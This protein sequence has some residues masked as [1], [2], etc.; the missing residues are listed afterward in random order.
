MR[1]LALLAPALAALALSGCA[2]SGEPDIATLASSSDDIIWEAAQKAASKKQWE[3]ARQHYKRIVDAF[4][5]SEHGADARLGLADSYFEEGGTGNY[6]LAVSAY[7]E[8]LTLFPSHPKSDYAQFRVGESFYRQ[9]NGPDRDQTATREALDEYERLLAR[10]PNSAQAEEGRERLQACRQTLARSEFMIGYFYQRSRVYCRAAVSRYEGI[11]S[12]YPDYQSLD[13]VLY[14][15]SECLNNEGRPSEARPHLT[16][17]I[18]QY[19]K[20]PF[21]APA[22]ELMD[23]LPA[24]SPRAPSVEPTPGPTPAPTPGPSP[25]PHP[26]SGPTD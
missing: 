10:Y 26:P 12:E 14:R 1:R 17:L 18:E 2:S 11:L 6:V 9:R 24:S 5:N 15:L 20:S 13:E 21:V 4:P 22:K 25:A 23:S 7:R 19:P 8:F 3:N 16:R